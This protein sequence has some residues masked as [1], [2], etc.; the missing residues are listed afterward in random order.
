M[1]MNNLYVYIIVKTSYSVKKLHFNNFFS[2]NVKIWKNIENVV[3]M[4]SLFVCLLN[5]ILTRCDSL[6]GSLCRFLN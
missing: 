1:N 5:P 3:Q 2:K 6:S 4:F